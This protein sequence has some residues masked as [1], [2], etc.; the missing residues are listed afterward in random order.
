[1]IDTTQIAEFDE[2]FSF[3]FPEFCKPLIAICIVGIVISLVK[4]F[5]RV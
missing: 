3:F 1:M 2:T 5:V 4:K